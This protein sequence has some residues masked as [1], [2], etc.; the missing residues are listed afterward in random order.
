[1]I[2]IKQMIL[3]EVRYID[4]DFYKMDN[5]SPIMDNETIRVYHG[6]GM[7][8]DK[9]GDGGDGDGTGISHHG[10]GTYLIDDRDTALIYINQYAV[11]GK[12][13]LYTCDLYKRESIEDWDSQIPMDTF[14]A[15]AEELTDIDNDLSQEMLNYPDS[16]GG[17]TFTFG[18]LYSLLESTDG[19]STNIFFTDYGIY[20][21]TATNRINPDATEFCV[22]DNDLIQ[23]IDKEN[24]E[25]E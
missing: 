21:F 24:I 16:Y 18:E 2:N 10:K 14:M 1:M 19:V 11:G 3:D 4:P 25:G 12:G 15:M 22:L 13:V 9:F 20:G 6:S 5:E 7:D 8:F 23:I 17:E